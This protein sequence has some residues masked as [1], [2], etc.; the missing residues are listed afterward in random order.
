SRS[1]VHCARR[2]RVMYADPLEVVADRVAAKGEAHDAALRCHVPNV[3]DA[4]LHADVVDITA[5]RIG[6]HSAEYQRLAGWLYADLAVGLAEG[7]TVVFPA[8]VDSC[9][10]G[11]VDFEGVRFTSDRQRADRMDLEDVAV[12]VLV[13]VDA[14]VLE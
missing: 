11:G 4:S 9:V 12:C 8:I 6:W 2:G 5:L 1:G 7:H 14:A 13:L 10:V 3:D